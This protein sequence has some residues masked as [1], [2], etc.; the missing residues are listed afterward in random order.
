MRML[1]TYQRHTVLTIAMKVNKYIKIKITLPFEWRTFAI[2]ECPM[3]GKLINWQ[4]IYSILFNLSLFF[5]L[6]SPSNSHLEYSCHGSWRENQT[7]FIIA[8]HTGTKHG[9]CISFKQSTTDI[10]M[11]QLYIGDSCYREYQV[12]DSLQ[13]QYS[14]ANLTNV[15][16]EYLCLYLFFH[17]HSLFFLLNFIDIYFHFL[18]WIFITSFFFFFLFSLRFT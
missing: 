10:S 14:I 3:S 12:L 6:Y 15:G 2:K 7:T 16:R 11:A 5:F 8:R 13:R 17:L 18:T 4:M 9:V 1:L